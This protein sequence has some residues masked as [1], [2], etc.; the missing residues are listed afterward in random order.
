[1][2][3][4]STTGVLGAGKGV[5]VGRAALSKGKQWRRHELVWGHKSKEVSDGTCSPK[6]YWPPVAPKRKVNLPLMKQRGIEGE[7]ERNNDAAEVAIKSKRGAKRQE[8]V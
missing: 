4:G 2:Q 6:G 3:G 1:L 8:K 7:R 5:C